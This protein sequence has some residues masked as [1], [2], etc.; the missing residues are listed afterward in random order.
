MLEYK[1]HDNGPWFLGKIGKESME[2]YKN[3][4]FKIWKNQL[5]QPVCEA[6]FKRLLCIGLVTTIYDQH[7]FPSPE[8]EKNDWIV[9]DD[10][11]RDVHIPRPVK[12]LRIWDPKKR[13]Y[14]EVESRLKDAPKVEEE[15]EYWK[16]FLDELRQ[17]RGTDYINDLLSSF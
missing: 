7:C 17:T 15:K 10:N 2:H 14:D 8:E 5:I 9:Q 6:S 1:F 4:K 11:G 3:C 12:K 13:G 16:G